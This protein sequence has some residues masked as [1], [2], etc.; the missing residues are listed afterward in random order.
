MWSLQID[1]G[2]WTEAITN[3]QPV[4]SLTWTTVHAD[5]KSVGQKEFY[6]ADNAGLKPEIVFVVR[7]FEY[8]G[9]EMVRWPSSTGSTYAILRTYEKGDY[10]ELVCGARVGELNG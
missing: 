5:K 9:H 2:E 6:A 7:S 4:R 8:D 10:L 3:G 1:L